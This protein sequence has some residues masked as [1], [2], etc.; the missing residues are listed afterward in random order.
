M[1]HLPLVGRLLGAAFFFF[2]GGGGSK[3]PH[4]SFHLSSSYSRCVITF[5]TKTFWVV[6]RMRVI[7]RYLLP[8]MLKITQS[9]TMLARANAVMQ[10]LP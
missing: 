9:P 7:S 2:G 4:S 6:Q 3:H 5:R 1:G 10:V 8:P